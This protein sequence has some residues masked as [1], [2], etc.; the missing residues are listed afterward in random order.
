MSASSFLLLALPA[1]VFTPLSTYCIKH[2]L[3]QA[4]PATSISYIKY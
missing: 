3:Q 2:F 1:F 4:F